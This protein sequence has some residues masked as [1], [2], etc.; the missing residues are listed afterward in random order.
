M[1]CVSYVA[2]VVSILSLSSRQWHTLEQFSLIANTVLRR[3][4]A[5]LP[6]TAHA[7]N[8]YSCDMYETLILAS[9]YMGKLG[10]MRSLGPRNFV[11]N[12]RYFVTIQKQ[13]KLIHWDRKKKKK[14]KEKKKK[15]KKKISLLYQVFC[16]IR[17][18]YID[19]HCTLYTDVRKILILHKKSFMDVL[20][21]SNDLYTAHHNW[22]GICHQL[23]IRHL[24]GTFNF[25]TPVYLYGTGSLFVYNFCGKACPLWRKTVLILR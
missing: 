20:P 19:F 15:K 5:M 3:K 6:K 17:S 12:I 2:S 8:E 13:R 16:Y 10:I 7:Q 11:C 21:I 1:K 18:L 4:R 24:Y 9:I 25:S 14:K 22:L 23:N